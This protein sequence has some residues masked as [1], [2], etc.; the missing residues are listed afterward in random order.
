MSGPTNSPVMSPA[1]VRNRTRSARA[2]AAH[3]R[4][5]AV[6]IIIAH[7]EIGLGSVRRFHGEE[8]VGANAEV[9]MAERRN[10]FAGEIDSERT[11]V[12][13]DEI[14]ARTGHFNEGKTVHDF[15]KLTHPP[16]KVQVRSA[17]PV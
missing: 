13:D 3:F 15:T 8:A 12:D 2:V 10:L 11:V 17:S 16:A 6:G 14:V 7:A 5:A 1:W 9:A 4:L